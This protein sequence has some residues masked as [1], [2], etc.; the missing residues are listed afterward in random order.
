MT[1]VK[2]FNKVLYSCLSQSCTTILRNPNY[3]RLVAKDLLGSIFDGSKC[4]YVQS[5]AS[6]A[7]QSCTT[8]LGNPNYQGL[9]SEVILVQERCFYSFLMHSGRSKLNVS[10]LTFRP[11]SEGDFS[12]QFCPLQLGL[13]RHLE[14]FDCPL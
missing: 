12:K 2:W 5:I 13:S 1:T 4:K 14:K 10:Q 11:V 9:S 3:H 8:I 6:I 7:C